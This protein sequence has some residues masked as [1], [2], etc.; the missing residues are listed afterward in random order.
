MDCERRRA[1]MA[2]LHHIFSALLLQLG[3]FT[4]GGGGEE[5][6]MSPI[7]VRLPPSKHGLRSSEPRP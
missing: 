2:T 1:S 3:G 5:G 4:G 7:Q 6:K